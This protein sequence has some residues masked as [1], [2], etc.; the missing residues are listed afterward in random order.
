MARSKTSVVNR[1]LIRI[2]QKVIQD[3][4]DDSNTAR[5]A[6][7]I[8]DENL[9]ECLENGPEKG[10]KFAR[11][12][13]SISAS[14]DAP[15]FEYDYKYAI[16][17]DFIAPISVQ[18]GGIELT[19]WIREGD[20][21]LTN[22]ED[23]EIDLV[24]VKRITDVAKYPSHFVKVLWNRLAAELSIAIVSTNAPL[25]KEIQAE[26]ETIILPRAKGLDER[27]KYVEES[28]TDWVNA[29]A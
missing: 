2:G 21:I 29:G 12:R 9:D 4:T 16:P 22:D 28:N 23:E 27:E 13:T 6:N 14:A 26:L 19:D 24:Y 3:T 1:A 25:K 20:W 10:W 7:A 15:A 18:V 8:W 11:E 17:A 5:L